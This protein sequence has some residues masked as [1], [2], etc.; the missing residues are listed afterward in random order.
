MWL[1]VC[2][3]APRACSLQYAL[4]FASPPGHAAGEPETTDPT[5]LGFFTQAWRD[6]IV[7]HAHNTTI[8]GLISRVA[9]AMPGRRF[10]AVAWSVVEK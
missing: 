2:V 3:C 6:A 8:V 5:S 7:E 10:G 9:I 1:C 4:C